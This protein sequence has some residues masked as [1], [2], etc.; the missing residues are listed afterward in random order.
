[1]TDGWQ[2]SVGSWQLAVPTLP[3]AASIDHI[4]LAMELT[5]DTRQL[6]TDN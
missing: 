4:A 5:I 6:A 2:L 1:M 3:G